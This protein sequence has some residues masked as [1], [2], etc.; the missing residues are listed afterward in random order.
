MNEI[1]VFAYKR[2]SH[3]TW[4]KGSLRNI[5]RCNFRHF[6]VVLVVFTLANDKESVR[7]YLFLT[8]Y[9]PTRKS[10]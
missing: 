5:F 3:M 4:N 6:V 7:Y 9:G 2:K 10:S 8:K 1:Y